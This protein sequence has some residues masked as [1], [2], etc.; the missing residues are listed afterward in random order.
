M[1]VVDDNHTNRD[2]FRAYLDAWGCVCDTAVDG[3][4][5]LAKLRAAAETAPYHAALV[6]FMMPGIAGAL[7]GG[8]LGAAAVDPRVRFS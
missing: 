6:D 5:G 3:E 7:W 4:T 8:M 2:L 1:L